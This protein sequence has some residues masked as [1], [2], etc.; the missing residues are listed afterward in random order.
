MTP[1]SSMHL[2]FLDWKRI[3]FG[4]NP[5]GQRDFLA[6]PAMHFKASTIKVTQQ[7]AVI[8]YQQ[9]VTFHTAL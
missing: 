1:S 9:L 6:I 4:D 7:D 5:A 3:H 8:R 2:I